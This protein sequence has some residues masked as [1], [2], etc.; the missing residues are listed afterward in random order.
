MTVSAPR[1][2]HFRRRPGRYAAT[3][4][5]LA[6]LCVALLGSVLLVSCGGDGEDSGARPDMGTAAP[7]ISPPGLREQA[8]SPADNAP[9]TSTL[10]RKEVVTGSVEITAA[11][12]GSRDD[13]PTNF[14][15]GVVAGWHS[16]VDW[17][18]DAIVFLGKAVPWL[19]FLALLGA[20]GWALLR[21]VR[22]RPAPAAGT[23]PTAAVGPDRRESAPQT[24]GSGADQGGAR[25]DQTEQP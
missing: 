8:P 3:M 24:G 2:I 18:Q 13:G 25:D 12:K 23:R 9:D 5:K 17:L 6:V 7:A 4:R 22:R 11:D 19:G 16:L 20:L 1:R 21:L 15:D 14:W 10:D